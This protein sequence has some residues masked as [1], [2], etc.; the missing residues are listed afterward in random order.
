M[1]LVAAVA[2][3]AV[4][5]VALARDDIY[6]T[7]PGVAIAISLVPPLA[8][9]GLTWESGAGDQ[10]LGALLLFCANVT[11]ILAPGLVVMAIYRVHALSTD[12][13]SISSGRRIEHR[14]RLV[15]AVAVALV[16][17]AVPLGLISVHINDDSNTEAAELSAAL[18]RSG[19]SEDRV[20]IELVPSRTVQLGG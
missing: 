13:P 6:D 15:A 10:A 17:V 3:G 20:E 19:L 1:V 5:S 9:V 16:A 8:V 11:A 7:L 2:T 14:G 4:G 18:K 12:G